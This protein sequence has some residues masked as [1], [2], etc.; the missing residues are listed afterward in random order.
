MKK[1]YNTL[2]RSKNKDIIN[3]K[4]KIKY[5]ELH[6]KKVKKETIYEKIN[7]MRLENGIII[8]NKIW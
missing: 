6:P 8:N 7:R 2:Y 4:R 1:E 3:A 5:R